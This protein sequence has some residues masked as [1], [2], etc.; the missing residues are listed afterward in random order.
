MPKSPS[1]I[2]LDKAI[3]ITLCFKEGKDKQQQ[4]LSSKLCLLRVE[5]LAGTMD[6]RTQDSPCVEGAGRERTKERG[7]PRTKEGLFHLG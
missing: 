4:N 7:K 3:I 5:V 2:Q 6:W 1:S